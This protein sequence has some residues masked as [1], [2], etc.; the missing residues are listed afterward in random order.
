[1]RFFTQCVALIEC[2]ELRKRQLYRSIQ[3]RRDCRMFSVPSKRNRGPIT[4]VKRDYFPRLPFEPMLIL[5][6]FCPFATWN[7]LTVSLFLTLF[8]KN[9]LS[10]LVFVKE[11]SCYEIGEDTEG[12]HRFCLC[13]RRV[14]ISSN[15]LDLSASFR[16]PHGDTVSGISGLKRRESDTVVLSSSMDSDTF[17]NVHPGVIPR[18]TYGSSRTQSL[19]GQRTVLF[20]ITSIG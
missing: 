18:L 9:R 1:M 15:F 16:F 14:S 10:R 13:I 19:S 11:V 3:R 12:S 17:K 6:R 7:S 20:L 2:Q 8:I 4:S 5:C